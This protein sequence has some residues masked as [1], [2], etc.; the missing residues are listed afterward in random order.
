MSPE[1]RPSSPDPAGTRGDVSST[2]SGRDEAPPERE[3][4]S[5]AALAAARLLRLRPRH[6]PRVPGQKVRDSLEI[7]RWALTIG[8]LLTF[9]LFLSLLVLFFLPGVATGAESHGINFDKPTKDWYQGPVRYIITKV[10]LKAYKSLETELDRQNFIDWFW[11]RR[12]SDPS[13]QKN[14]FRERYEQ[15]VFEA[16]RMFADTSTPGWKTDMGKVYIL[17]GPPDEQNKDVMARSHRGIVTWVYRKAPIP[18]QGGNL[19]VGFAKDASGEFHLSTTPTIDSDVARGLQFARTPITIDDQRIIPGLDPAMLAAGASLNQGELATMMM[20][21]ELQQLPPKEEEMFRTLVST[22]EFFTSIPAESQLDCYQG[23]DGN[24][25]AT[26]TI[27]IKSSAVQYHT[28]GEKERPDV[29]VF[30]KLVNRKHPDEVYPLASESNFVESQE[31]PNAGPTDMLVF[32]ATGAFKPGEYELVL[33]LQD[34]VAKR[35]SSYRKNV[36]IPDLASKDLALSTIAVAGTLDP[37]EYRVSAGKPFFIGKFRIVPRPDFSFKK[38]EELNLYFQVYNPAIDSETGRPKLDV[39]YNFRFRKDDGSYA[40]VGTYG[41]KAS[42]AQVQGYAV[43]LE[44]WP[45]GVYQVKV[46]LNDT[47]SGKSVSS[48]IDFTMQP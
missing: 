11:Q 18:G 30:G 22:H 17:M 35:V 14:E 24:T 5:P 34:R 7:P 16:T 48:Q 37:V 1:E 12:D 6:G 27:G 46:T 31:N 38:S 45:A 33:G 32:Q 13:T 8:I 15:R 26:I 10:E 44:K 20:Y 28:V 39:F 2:P 29:V 43:S 47:I 3:V 23:T 42:G 4:V 40:E 41:V 21:G 25:F 9:L 36:S 19:V